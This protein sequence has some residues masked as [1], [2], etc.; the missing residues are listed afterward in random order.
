MHLAVK[1]HRSLGVYYHHFLVE[2]V[3]GNKVKIIQNGKDSKHICFSSIP[4]TGIHRTTVN[5]EFEN[6]LFDFSL[7]LFLI[8]NDNYPETPEQGRQALDRALSRIGEHK[9]QLSINNCEHF[10]TFALTGKPYSTQLEERS[11]IFNSFV[12]YIVDCLC[13]WQT[14]VIKRVKSVGQTLYLIFQLIWDITTC[15]NR[16][17]ELIR[18]KLPLAVQGKVWAVFDWMLKNFYHMTDLVS[19]KFEMIFDI[20]ESIIETMHF[21]AKQATIL[22]QEKLMSYFKVIQ[23]LLEL[24][25]LFWEIYQD[26][27][28][29]R[30]GIISAKS[31]LQQILKRVL[32]SAFCAYLENYGMTEFIKSIIFIG[33]ANECVVVLLAHVLITIAVPTVID[34]LKDLGLLCMDKAARINAEMQSYILAPVIR[35]I[36]RYVH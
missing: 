15:I 16:Y 14:S 4:R 31:L 10:V 3:H 19:T 20:C 27:H 30:K 29:W 18:D 22:I 24:G 13:D 12:V 23:V 8:K 2:E 26:V 28:R 32:A 1:R 9:Y 7:G 17:F 35:T 36:A 25:I 11:Y 6:D 5:L 34:L 21:F 33:F